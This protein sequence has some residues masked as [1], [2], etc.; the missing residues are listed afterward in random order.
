MSI[1]PIRRVLVA[2]DFSPCS[3]A[4]A[5]EAA[6][7]AKGTQTTIHLLHVFSVMPM[8]AA[9]DAAASA[10]SISSTV[11]LERSLEQ[12]LTQQLE[13]IATAMRREFPDV[14]FEGVVREGAAAET[15][16][17]EAA[18]A[19]VDRIVVGTHG[20][21]GLSHLLL[22]SVAERVARLAKVPVLVVKS[23]SE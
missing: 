14:E 17:D 3:Q 10:T 7:D 16:L 8:P 2:H 23:P 11:E 21:T 20:R 4:A 6:R 15:I 5:R 13:R 19:R 1:T 12:E 9:I 18:V 22:G